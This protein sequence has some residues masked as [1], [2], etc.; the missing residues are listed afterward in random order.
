MIVTAP[1]KVVMWGEYAV[2]AGAPAAVMAVDRLA[3]VHLEMAEATRISAAGFL[4]PGI[5]TPDQHFSGLPAAALVEHIFRF[6]GYTHYPLQ[7]A[8]YLDTSA[9]FSAGTKYGLGSSA[10]LCVAL[11]VGLAELL[12]RTTSLSEA[13]AIHRSWQGNRG[14]GLDVASTWHGGVI[15]FQRGRVEPFKLPKDLHWRLIWTGKQA[16]TPAHLGDFNRWRDNADT[17]PLKR[18]AT[19]AEVLFENGVDLHTLANYIDAL[20]ALDAAAKL[21]IYTHE[22]ARLATIAHR[23]QVL[24][25]PCGAGGG[26]IGLAIA[27]DRETL[28]AFIATITSE[29]QVLSTEIAKHGVQLTE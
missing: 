1:A 12:G 11:Y 10:A 29:F 4:A 19:Q 28:Q 17:A 13:M 9:F 5:Y 2:L 26:D 8:M 14:S 15:R 21:N 20:Q 22:H 7:A 16:S 18:L 3:R 25:K 27:N 24:Y 23:A 6:W